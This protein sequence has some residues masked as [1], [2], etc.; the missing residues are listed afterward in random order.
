MNMRVLLATDGSE[1]AERAIELAGAIS[2]PEGTQFRLVMAVEPIEHNLS[3]AWVLPAENNSDRRTKELE[4]AA[5]AVLGHAARELATTGMEISQRVMRGRPA[6][7]IVENA[8]HF[9]ANLVIVGSRGHGT[10]ASMVLGSVSAEVV[11]H[12]PCPVLVARDTRLTRAVLG[13]DGSTFAHSAEEFVARWP[14]FQKVAIE[15]VSVI[16]LGTTWTAGLALSLYN[17]PPEVIA[18]TVD[19]IQSDAAAAA[20]RLKESGLRVSARVVHG[21]AAAELIRVAGNDQAD[22]IVVG[23]HGR[24]GLARLVLGSVARNVMLHAPCS[25]LVVREVRSDLSQA[26]A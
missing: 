19:A 1:A 22:L 4:D 25:V 6:T 12:A 3:A 16:D 8:H 23:T 17:P 21:K 7:K 13:Y 18:E 20:R 15:V 11:D 14:I 2:W 24:T 9:A 10:I 26:A 5:Q